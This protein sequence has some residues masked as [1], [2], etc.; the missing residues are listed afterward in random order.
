MSESDTIGQVARH[1]HQAGFV[2]VNFGATV[3]SGRGSR[4]GGTGQQK[5]VAPVLGA[6]GS[7]AIIDRAVPEQFRRPIG[8]AYESSDPGIA[9]GECESEREG[10]KQGGS[11][12]R[13][14]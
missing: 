14:E 13:S 8:V 7:H 9:V 12:L 2:H 1:G 5:S 6:Y 4:I 3:A 11:S 10:E